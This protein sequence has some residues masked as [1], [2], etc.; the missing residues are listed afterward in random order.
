MGSAPNFDRPARWPVGETASATDFVRHFGQ[1]AATSLRQP[2]YITQH[3]RVNWAL[4]SADLM[5]QLERTKAGELSDDARLDIILDSIA[6]LV[7][8]FDDTLNIAQMNLA[9]RRHFQ[10]SDA[11]ARSVHLSALFRSATQKYL[12]DVCK[13]VAESGNAETFEIDSDLYPGR[14]LNIQIV[15]SPMGVVLTADVASQT[16]LVRRTYAAATAA[17]EAADATDILGR[18]R[19]N[20]RGTITAANETLA[21]LAQTSIDKISGLR[22]SSLFDQDTRNAV[23]DCVETMLTTGEPFSL[24]ANLLD[25]THKNT[26]VKLGAGV[27]R[28]AGSISGAAFLVIAC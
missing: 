4:V 2:I 28:D 6:T 23:R 18:G 22:L 12:I 20:I 16:V 10:L 13:R 15:K 9:A 5:A 8:Q 3:G 26:R 19:I 25:G 24:D 17:A 11:E 7:I 14:T 1:Y 27:E 21:K